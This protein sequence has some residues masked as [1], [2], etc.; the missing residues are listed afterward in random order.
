MDIG[1]RELSRE[2]LKPA[3]TSKREVAVTRGEIESAE[4]RALNLFDQWVEVTGVVDRH[5]TYYYELQAVIRDAVHCGIQQTLG[6]CSAVPSRMS[7]G[8]HSYFRKPE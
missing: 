8:W 2:A 3:E 5:T 4:R 1:N 7:G 6:I